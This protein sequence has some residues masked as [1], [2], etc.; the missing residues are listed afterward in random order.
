MQK[1]SSPR[2]AEDSRFSSR[3]FCRWSLPSGEDLLQFAVQW[4]V[5]FAMAGSDEVSC[6][7]GRPGR[8]AQ[9]KL[10]MGR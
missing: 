10:E 5:A 1:P 3:L 6:G 7:S 2:C 8:V 9:L 4:P